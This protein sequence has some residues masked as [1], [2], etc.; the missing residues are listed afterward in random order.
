MQNETEALRN[1]VKFWS[2]FMP[3]ENK[4]AEDPTMKIVHHRPP[5]RAPPQSILPS[6]FCTNCAVKPVL[7]Q[8]NKAKKPWES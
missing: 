6:H 5:I 3:A 7:R 4:A 1:T 8:H 2:F